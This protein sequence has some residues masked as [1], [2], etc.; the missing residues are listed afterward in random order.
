MCLGSGLA[1]SHLEQRLHPL[2]RVTEPQ[3]FVRFA[4]DLIAGGSPAADH[5]SCFAKKRNRKKATPIHHP[6]GVPCAARQAGRLRNSRFALRQSSPTA[7]GLAAL[8]GG[9]P[10]EG[11]ANPTLALPLKGRVLPPSLA[12]PPRDGELFGAP[13]VEPPPFSPLR[14]FGLAGGL[15]GVGCA[16]FEFRGRARF[17]C[18]AR[19][20]CADAQFA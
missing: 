1:K 17:V 13:S 15:G 8:L 11:K 20:S 12:K 19:A 10:R 16:L 6:Y 3:G 14:R 5:L 4:S 9:G 7:P 2:I 18:A